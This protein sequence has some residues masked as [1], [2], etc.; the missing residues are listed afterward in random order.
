MS[1]FG[2][3]LR[4]LIGYDFLIFLLAAA[5]AAIYVATRRRALKLYKA[6]RLV[7]FLPVQPLSGGIIKTPAKTFQVDTFVKMREEAESLYAIFSNLTAIFPLM[8][9]LGTVLSLLPMVADMA[10]VQ[11]NFFAALTSTFWGLVFA[12]AFKICDAFLTSRMEDNDKNVTLLLSRVGTEPAEE[13]DE[14]APKTSAA[15]A[16]G[17]AGD[18]TEK[19][20]EDA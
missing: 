19:E 18:K 7:I 15:K 9:I 8:G 12:I 5:N 14:K 6:L 1:V 2:V 4:N 17:K 11:T 10:N 3:I 16:G 20:E 13:T